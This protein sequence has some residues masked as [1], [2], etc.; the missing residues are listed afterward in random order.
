MK[1]AILPDRGIIK[2]EGPDARTFLQ[3]L[4]SNDVERADGSGAVYAAFLT[5][6]GKYLFDFFIIGDG[7]IL[8]L[9]TAKSDVPDL[10]KRLTMYKLRS[11]ATLEDV[12]G[13]MDVAVIFGDG[14][15]GVLTSGA[16]QEKRSDGA[17]LYIDPRLPAAGVRAIL[18]EAA[19]PAALDGE[20]ADAED[21]ERHRIML[22]LPEAPDDLIKDK[23][24]LL[25][26]GFD[27]LNGVDWKKGC[28][29]GQELTARTKY[30]GLVKKRLVP[31]SIDGTVE[32][33]TDILADGKI[34][35]D[36]R[37]V[38]GDTGIA[39]LRLAAIQSGGTLSAGDATL[40]VSVPDWMQLPE[41]VD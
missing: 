36:V 3:G 23:S 29:M 6:Q 24:I 12:S 30:R 31:V 17:I 11:K 33:G 32:T 41:E 7:E 27:E 1:R 38:A 2:I 19:D 9:E 34:V 40:S 15:D 10:I 22:G 37:S 35:G 5:P 13:N 4:V 20:I 16:A 26:S 14:S 21:F 8:Y 25:E 28:Y 39:M 18:P